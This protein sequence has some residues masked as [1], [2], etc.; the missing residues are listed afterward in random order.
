MLRM[1]LKYASNAQST[2]SSIVRST[3]ARHARAN[4][5]SRTKRPQLQVL[6]IEQC[7]S[8]RLSGRISDVCTFR[9]CQCYNV[10]IDF[11]NL[12]VLLL[13]TSRG[14]HT[15]DDYFETQD[16][17]VR[18]ND[19]RIELEGKFLEFTDWT[20]VAQRFPFSDRQVLELKSVARAYKRTSSRESSRTVRP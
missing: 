3:N 13:S 9:E 12:N 18:P 11:L 14:R 1:W 10:E 4:S 19:L 16:A 5:K 8:C 7:D 20:H 6:P 2:Q 17:T 15:I